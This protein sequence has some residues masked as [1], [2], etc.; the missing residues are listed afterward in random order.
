MTTKKD[1]PTLELVDDI[2]PVTVGDPD[3]AGDLSIDQ[4]HLEEYVSSGSEG[5][6]AAVECKR[7]PRGTMFT[8]RAEN[9]KP[10][11]DRA[12]FWFL[13]MEGHDPYIVTPAIAKQK[14]DDEDTIR[15][16]LIVRYV[17]MAGEEALWALKL[18]LDGRSNA[19]NAS[20]MN[21]LGFADGSIQ[22]PDNEVKGPKWVRI[23]SA[24][25]GTGKNKHYRYQVSKKT[26][27]DT[28]PKFSRRRFKELINLC[29]KGRIV[30]SL[31]HE[32]WQ[33]L[34][35]GNAK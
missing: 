17:T 12:F 9:S 32:I 2:A 6:A 8:A 14:A 16:V 1:K 22:L 28:P 34:K 3:A 7:P 21:I 10:W 20:A 23:M 11:Q 29:F 27:E 15:P 26:L 18:D 30:S 35:E 13:E 33:I 31:D 5:D 25:R 19:Y 4:E 24:A